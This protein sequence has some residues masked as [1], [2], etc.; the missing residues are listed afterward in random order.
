VGHLPVSEGTMA[1]CTGCGT[2]VPAGAAA[3]PSCGKG[4]A[5]SPVTTSAS[6]G[7]MT[8]NVASA[9]AYIPIVGL[10]FLFVE[11]YNKNRTVRFHC[12]QILFFCLACIVVDFPPVLIPL[13]GPLVIV[14]LLLLGE[15]VVWL[16]MVLKAYQG[17]KFKLPFIGDI[18]EQQ[19]N[20]G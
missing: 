8:D 2:E 11:P 7:G 15:S 12:F 13:L 20:A 6:T 16:I 1:F 14:P 19:A 17:A 9:L 10:I 3:C 4:T 18:A 5:S